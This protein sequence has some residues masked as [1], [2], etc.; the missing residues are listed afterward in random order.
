MCLDFCKE[1]SSGFIW[2]KGGR[3]LNMLPSDCEA[4]GLPWLWI[5]GT[6]TLL[7]ENLL[8]ENVCVHPE[9]EPGVTSIHSGPHTEWL[10]C[11]RQGDNADVSNEVALP[12]CMSFLRLL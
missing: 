3:L 1:P 6:N 5:R 12:D 11:I 8:H 2:E 9:T 10:V 7:P 4:D